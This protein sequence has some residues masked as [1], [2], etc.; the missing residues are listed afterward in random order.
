MAPAFLVLDGPDGCGKTTQTRLL[1]ERL[2]SLGRNPLVVRDPGGTA[3]GDRVRDV[4]LDP[5]LSE[6]DV[7]TELLLYLASRAQLVAERI[8]PALEE[9]RDVVCD[10]Y[11]TSTV[12][13]QAHAGGLD[14]A[15]V[16]RLGLEAVGGP[17]PDLCILLDVPTAVA[18][19]RISSEPDR[20]EARG[21]EFQE[22]V[23][24]G[25]RLVSA[26]GP[27]RCALVNGNGPVEE[28]AARVWE[29]VRGVL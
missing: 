20:M 25:F 17:D 28:V 12:A 22:R 1:V 2:E 3:V 15:L 29:G 5:A 11:L 19:A 13:Y 16:W 10:R 8:V 23:R 27:Y 14:P 21:L 6:M 26:E 7:R 9:E 18:Y 4:L 24:Q